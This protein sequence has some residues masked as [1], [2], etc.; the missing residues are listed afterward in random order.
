VKNAFVRL[1]AALVTLMPGLAV[2]Q[3]GARFDDAHV[4]LNDPARWVRLMDQ[5]GIQ[6]A[7]AFRGRAMDHAGLVAAA[8]RWPGRLLP[9]VSVSP[10][11]SEHRRDWEEDNAALARVVDSLLATGFY[12]GI[13]EISVSHF[14]G[15]GFPE[16]DFD[17]NG[18]AM[19]GILEVARR[20]RVP[21]AI[22]CEITRLHE[23]EKL[24][25]AFP[26]VRVIWAHGGYTPLFLAERVLSRHPNLTYEMS[27]RTWRNHPRS[28][29]YTITAN[30]REVWP[31]WV[32]L[33]EAKPERFVVGTDAALRSITSDQRKIES[34]HRF[35][36]QLSPGTRARVARENLADLIRR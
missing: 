10:E 29:D 26:D 3:E 33:V 16:A 12:Y 35:L 17:P 21:V 20:Y 27:A 7:I 14:P 25:D 9:F 23:L 18:R 4:H 34:V 2:A 15:N 28:P 19:H 24:L 30:D 13:G 32:A 22:H 31:E 5:A 36:L 6:R 11:H 8:A 1:G